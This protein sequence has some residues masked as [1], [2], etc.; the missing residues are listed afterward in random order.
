[1]EHD[2]ERLLALWPSVLTCVRFMR[3]DQMKTALQDAEK[4]LEKFV[5][6]AVKAKGS[7][8]AAETTRDSLKGGTFTLALSQLFCLRTW[9]F[10]VDFS[11]IWSGY[12]M[13][14]WL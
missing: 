1:M 9:P 5:R 3:I 10:P 8:R 7:L 12:G 6:Q 13:L 2:S 14:G 4:D 11:R